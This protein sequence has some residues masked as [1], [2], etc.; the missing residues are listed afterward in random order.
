MGFSVRR[1][2]IDKGVVK[3]L[4]VVVIRAW[5]Y[6]KQDNYEP[7]KNKKQPPVNCERGKK[8]CNESTNKSRGK[9]KKDVY[10]ETKYSRTGCIVVSWVKLNKERYLLR[11]N[12]HVSNIRLFTQSSWGREFVGFVWKDLHSRLDTDRKLNQIVSDAEAALMWMLIKRKEDSTFF[13]MYTK[14]TEGRLPNLFWRDGASFNDYEAYGDI[15]IDDNMYKTMPLV[16]FVGANNHRGIVLFGCALVSDKK[17][18]T[19]SWLIEKFM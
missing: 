6:S 15:L 18:E 17:K 14:D 9:K 11:S 19:F 5:C 16:L 4:E 10:R 7:L 8:Q 2:K 12:R 13:A 3:G 1:F